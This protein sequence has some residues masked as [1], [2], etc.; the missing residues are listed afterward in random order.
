MGVLET[1][2]LRIRRWGYVQNAVLATVALSGVLAISVVAPNTLQLLGKVPGVKARFSSQ[3]HSALSRLKQKGYI[4]FSKKG[5]RAFVEITPAGQSA[6]NLQLQRIM[7]HPKKR[8]DKR[9][10]MVMFDIPEKRKSVR[11]RLR[12]TMR[13]A[14]FLHLQDSVWVYPHD[15]EELIALL[16][17]EMHIGKDILYAIVEKLE[18]D[19]PLKQ[20]FGIRV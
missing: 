3:T 8:W 20:H 14:G 7:L 2:A 10:R 6:L 5:T 13:E 15:C 1:E 4:S 12:R 16:K 17:A 19:T 11:E 9:W 18:N